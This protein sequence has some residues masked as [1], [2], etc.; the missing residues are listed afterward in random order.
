MVYLLH[1]VSVDCS[2]CTVFDHFH[3]YT[4]VWYASPERSWLYLSLCLMAHTTILPSCCQMI[5]ERNWHAASEMLTA[6]IAE[7]NHALFCFH[8]NFNISEIIF[9]SAEWNHWRL[10]LWCLWC[11]MDGNKQEKIGFKFVVHISHHQLVKVSGY[12][13]Q[14]AYM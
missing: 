10:N 8:D 5:A 9:L 1:S 11:E 7:E 3:I 4:D 14:C 13:E 12:F 6:L 2:C